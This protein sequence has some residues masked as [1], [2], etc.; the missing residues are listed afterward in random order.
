MAKQ[1]NNWTLIK[2][3]PLEGQ[4]NQLENIHIT[5]YNT[6][7]VKKNEVNPHVQRMNPTIDY[8]H[9][10]PTQSCLT[11]CDPKD[12]SLPGSYVHRIFQARILEGLPFL[13]AGD[14]L[15]PGVEPTSPALA[16]RFFDHC[17]IWEA[18]RSLSELSMSQSNYKK[19]CIT[20]AHEK[21]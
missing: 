17:D 11:L 15:D 16:G 1:E 18:H 19:H 10:M 9:N 14:L 12:Y 13:T 2:Y 3:L 21:S 7:W 6:E 5:G 20:P 8:Y 4:L